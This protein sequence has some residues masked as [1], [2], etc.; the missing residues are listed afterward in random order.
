[1]RPSSFVGVVALV[2][3]VGCGDDPHEPG[4]PSPAPVAT[5][6]LNVE[7]DTLLVGSALQLEATPRDSA[8]NPL[9][10]RAVE[11]S[12]SDRELAT[13]LDGAVHAR[14]LGVVTITATSEGKSGSATIALAP[15]VTVGRRLPTTF[16]GD[17]TG[18][19]VMLTDVL[20]NL[21]AGPVE[22]SSSDESVATVTAE[23]IVT[24][25]S[26]G[27]A[28]IRAEA[29]SGSGSV[30][31]VVLAPRV[32]PNREIAYLQVDP[33]SLHRI[34]ADG[35]GVIQLTG[36]HEDVIGFDW[37]PSGDR[38]ALSLLPRDAE[39]R[40][41]L[42]TLNPDGS[43]LRELVADA[44]QNPRWS[45]DGQRIL[46]TRESPAEVYVVRADGTALVPLTD[47]DVDL[48]NPEWSP[49]GRR[50][51]VHSHDCRRFFLLDAD[52][53]ANRQEIILPTQACSHAWSPDGK[54]I[55]Y[56]SVASGS[57]GIWLVNSDGA[58]PRPLTDNCTPEGVC[59]GDRYHQ[60]P[61]WS[62]DGRRLAWISTDNVTGFGMVHI[63]NLDTE[64][65]AE[66]DSG[67]PIDPSVDWS[68]DGTRLAYNGRNPNG[69]GSVV[70]SGVDGSGP[71]TLT[72]NVN[73]FG[74]R[75]RK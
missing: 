64:T 12:T 68:P 59:T 67:P 22:W 51:G 7:N 43:D 58:D 33:Y 1:M 69:W 61:R 63:Y 40:S 6:T 36:S 53:G 45:P 44:G 41:G 13:V 66:F 28:T 30:E 49:D 72:G 32:R 52:K 55:A 17:T 62:P 56:Y 37:S 46:L 3:G 18:L 25:V 8:G 27:E 39:G 16:A 73:S 20:G 23:G 70:V 26:A 9:E 75:W 14:A 54:L 60:L 47:I 50:V 4:E 5:V 34:G 2:I 10:D 21:L 57:M 29:F 19:T 15:L 74:P 35:I 11:W 71:V 31:L 65:F 42:H 38:I 48:W 24:G